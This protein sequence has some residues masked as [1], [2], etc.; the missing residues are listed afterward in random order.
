[1]N[2]GPPLPGHD[3]IV[4][5]LR[6]TTRTLAREVS[7]PT[8][9]APPWN[10]FEWGV[11]RAVC[12]MQGLG[13]LLANRT[14]WRAPHAWLAF[15]DD[16]R[17]QGLAHFQHAGAVLERLDAQARAAGIPCI[18]L[19]GS[20]LRAIRLHPPGE[21]PMGDID[22]LVPPVHAK[23]CAAMLAGMG[24]RPDYSTSRHDVFAP[25]DSRPAH[26]FAE[27]AS[28]PLRIE[29]HTRVAEALPMT[30]V[31]ITAELWPGCLKPGINAYPTRVALMRHIL[32]H[33]AGNMRAHAMRFSQLYDIAQLARRLEPDEWAALAGREPQAGSWWIYPPLLLAEREVPGSISAEVLALFRSACPRWLRARAGR[34]DLYE[35]SWSNLRIGALPGCEWARTPLELLRYARHRVA[36]ARD[37]REVLNVSLLVQPAYARVRWYGASHAERIV[38]WLFS[39]PP[40][41]QTITSVRA[42]LDHTIESR[43]WRATA[44][45]RKVLAIRLQALGDTIITLPYLLDLKRRHPHVELHFMTLESADAVPRALGFF[46]EVITIRG[47]R[48]GRLQF[49]WALLELP[50]LWWRRYDVVIDLQNHRWSRIVRRLLAPA[51]WSAFDRFSPLPHGERARRTIDATWPW[52]VTLDT[53]LRIPGGDQSAVKLLRANG[54]KDD[55]DLVVLNP[56]GYGGSRSWPIENYCAFAKAWLRV[57]NPRTQFVLLLM[58]ALREKARVIAAALGDGCIDLTGRAGQADAFAVLRRC[59]FVL[60]EDSGLGHMAWVQGVPTLALLSSSRRDWSAPQGAWSDCLDS[61]DLE[62]GPCGKPVCKYGDNRCLTRYEP[63]YVL[64]RASALL[65][66]RGVNAGTARAS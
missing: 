44:P 48:N 30:E 42:A 27:H 35:V 24:Y 29:V 5:A 2:D 10:D 47:G 17:A 64:A 25:A 52:R 26:D 9:A 16:Q 8:D 57:R 45:P 66:S 56:A 37:A 32:L 54:W 60:T 62:C 14:R 33:T 34:Y 40:R 15:L 41:V 46:D 36:P 53:D 7:A 38:R 12:A 65:D 21:R 11:A 23:A 18:A 4:A 6:A 39:R 31:D 19:K 59:T 22:I 50:R 51:A 1:V 63:A 58:P 13:A 43:P 55:H 20:A 3:V 28:N 49:L 61:S